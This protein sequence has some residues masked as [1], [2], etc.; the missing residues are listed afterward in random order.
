MSHDAFERLADALDELPNRF[1]RTES[2]VEID[3]L[4]KL[5]SPEE[6]ALLSQLSRTMETSDAVAE[7]MGGSSEQV[8]K[9]LIELARRGLVW[10][11]KTQGELRFRLPPF[12]VGIYEA[13]LDKV[14][15]ELAHLI[16]HYMLEGG[17]EGIMK[18][19]PA[20]HRVVPAQSAVKSEWI[21]PYDDVRSILLSSKGFSVYDCICRKQQDKL[22]T[23]K[24]D[25]PL[26]ICMSFSPAER[27]PGPS[28]VSQEEALALLQEAEEIG[29]VHTVSNV[30]KGVGYICNCCGCCCGILRGI[31]EWGIEKSVAYA[32]YYAVVDPEKCTACGVCEDRCQVN[33]ISVKEMAAVVDRDKC[34]GCD[35]CVTGC[36]EEAARLERRP[37]SETIDPPH[38]FSAWEQERIKQHGAAE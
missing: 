17:A 29:L 19:Q 32:N 13:S 27:P 28:T 3:I 25:F 15:H 23:R 36:T 31:T 9:K 16:E 4:K 37:D 5:L 14:D 7:R 6:A 26:R 35:L 22:G 21:L 10:F 1:P 12:I 34:I 2:G 33:A 8:Y 11:E 24:C 18:P 30:A 38:D 20:I